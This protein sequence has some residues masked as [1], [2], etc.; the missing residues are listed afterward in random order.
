MQAFSRCFFFLQFIPQRGKASLQLGHSNV[1]HLDLIIWKRNTVH[2]FNYSFTM[3]TLSLLE[4][5]SATVDL[6]LYSVISD[7]L[8]GNRKL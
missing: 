3:N 1:K 7:A 5:F 2:L 8:S 4:V 6:R